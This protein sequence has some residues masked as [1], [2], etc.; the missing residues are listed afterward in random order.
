[1]DNP[2]IVPIASDTNKIYGQVD[3]NIIPCDENGNEDLDDESVPDDPMELLNNTLDFKV[4]IDRLMNLPEN[5]CRNVYCE[6]TFYMDDHKYTTEV[7][8]GK[9]TNP[10]IQYEKHHHVDCVT[11][12]L[13]D[14][15][16]EDC[17]TIKVYAL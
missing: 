6:Y 17:L 14:Y 16:K 11:K 8:E 1:M 10:E 9:C 3:V 15:L 4:K 2:R 12:F 7:Y 5:F 13:I